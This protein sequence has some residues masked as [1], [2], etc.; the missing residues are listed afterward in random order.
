MAHIGAQSDGC[1][2]VVLGCVFRGFVSEMVHVISAHHFGGQQVVTIDQPLAITIGPDNILFV[3]TPDH[4]L[5]VSAVHAFIQ[6]GMFCSG[7][8]SIHS[9][10]TAYFQQS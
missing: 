10:I 8:V 2:V 7:K 6:I 1:H 5:H 4:N 3:S 9:S